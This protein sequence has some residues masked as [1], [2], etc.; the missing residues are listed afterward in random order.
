MDAKQNISPTRHILKNGRWD[1]DSFE[2]VCPDNFIT[3]KRMKKIT[4]M[5]RSKL[6][7]REVMPGNTNLEEQS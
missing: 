7:T 1:S 6:L 2:G 3:R 4:S 5:V